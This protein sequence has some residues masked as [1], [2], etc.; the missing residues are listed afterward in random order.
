MILFL[1]M[2]FIMCVI[3]LD[4]AYRL[5]DPDPSELESMDTTLLIVTYD[6]EESFKPDLTTRTFPA[7]RYVRKA[8]RVG[9]EGNP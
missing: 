5:E 2:A 9:R 6:T 4:V 3:L 7:Y 1:S 8:E